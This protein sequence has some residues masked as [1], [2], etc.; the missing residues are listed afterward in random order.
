M[1]L[2]ERRLNRADWLMASVIFATALVVRLVILFTSPDRA[3]PH[4]ILYEGDAPTWVAWANALDRGESFEFDLPL[5]S[6][7]IAWLLSAVHPGQLPASFVPF[8]MLWCVFTALACAVTY[9]AARRDFGARIA[10]IA[11]TFLTFS[12]GVHVISTSLN[13]EAVYMLALTLIALGAQQFTREPTW[14]LATLLGV[15]NGAAMLIRLEHVAFLISLGMWFAWRFA[16]ARRSTERDSAASLPRLG[17]VALVFVAALSVCLPWSIRG[18]LATQRFNTITSEEPDFERA[19]PSWTIEARAAVQLLP[20]FARDANFRY[21]TFLSQQSGKAQVTEHDVRAFFIEQF[22]YVPEPL[23]NWTLLSLKGP[24][25]FALANHPKAVGGFSKAALMREGDVDP[26]IMFGRP[27]HLKLFNHGYSIGWDYISA[28]FGGWLA[29]VG[30]KCSNFVDGLAMGFTA[31]NLPLGMSGE[32]RPVDMFTA[33]ANDSPK[34]GFVLISWQVLVLAL[35]G[36]GAAICVAQRRGGIWLLIIAYK[37]IITIVFYGY[38]RQAVSI[39][40]ASFVLMAVAIDFFLKGVVKR[41]VKDK[42]AFVTW[43]AAALVLLGIDIAGSIT[44]PDLKVTG[45][46][47]PAPQWGPA[48]FESPAEIHL[49]PIG[50]GEQQSR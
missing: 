4:S 42:P 43:A 12:F 24:V 29:R 22:G 33:R 31:R 2:D 28:D 39:A 35:I 44:R 16:I 19:V 20:A 14:W 30:S 15:A 46:I 38:A 49:A 5:R 13:N 6:P 3:W 41:H 7:G 26:T 11:A 9:L 8:K 50:C 45:S 32:R 21:I 18:S 1:S 36:C 40:P 34:H 47:S 48:S 10:L 27:D 17:L 23:S 25:D 37:V